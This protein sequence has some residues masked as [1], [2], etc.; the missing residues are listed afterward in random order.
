MHGTRVAEHEW[1]LVVLRKRC[2]PQGVDEIEVEQ[3]PDQAGVRPGRRSEEVVDHDGAVATGEPPLRVD[4]VVPDETVLL[5][6]FAV[7][8]HVHRIGERVGPPPA[9]VPPVLRPVDHAGARRQMTGMYLR[10]HVPR[11][12][13]GQQTHRSGLGHV[14]TQRGTTHVDV[15]GHRGR[16]DAVTE[17]AVD[18]R[19]GST[20]R[21][22]DLAAVPRV[23]QLPVHESGDHAAT[24]MGGQHTD[25]GDRRVRYPGTAGQGQVSARGIHGADEH[26][27]EEGAPRATGLE[28]TAHRP[29]GNLGPR[30]QAHHRRAEQRGR[31]P[32][33]GFRLQNSDLRFRSLTHGTT[34][35]SANLHRG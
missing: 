31:L 21:R 22:E 4:R 16:G 18:G 23:A 5:P 34:L 32:Q 7:H 1:E 3:E 30:G 11:I 19:L 2:E 10:Q 25:V 24:R 13:I 35:S 27:V 12:R 33:F 8:R 29:V 28:V 26:A 20:Q 9:R 14:G 15:D 6:R 17:P